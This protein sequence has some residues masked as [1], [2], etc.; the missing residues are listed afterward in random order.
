MVFN[1]LSKNRGRGAVVMAVLS[2]L[3]AMASV[4]VGAS[5]AKGLFPI[6]GPTPTVM[7]R[8]FFA[9]L[10][11]ILIWRPWRI[12]LN[13]QNFRVVTLYG[14]CLGLMN[15]TFYLSLTKIPLG[16]CVALEFT[17]PL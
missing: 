17:G 16:I 1:P 2:L 13:R 4:Q 3:I 12:S 8:T 7:L 9:A 11:L 15:L 6:L 14:A 10:L 5:F